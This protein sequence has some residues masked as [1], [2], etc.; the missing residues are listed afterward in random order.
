MSTASQDALVVVVGRGDDPSRWRRV[1]PAILAEATASV[2]RTAASRTLAVVLLPAVDAVRPGPV[3]VLSPAGAVSSYE[4]HLAA[5][6]AA[7]A[8]CR[9]EHVNGRGAAGSALHSGLPARAAARTA[10]TDWRE[11]ANPRP[12]RSLHRLSS[13][14]SLLVVSVPPGSADA[15][16]LVADHPDA[17]IVLVF[18]AVHA[19]HGAE[20]AR[21]VG[22]MVELALGVE[23]SGPE[24][25]TPDVPGAPSVEDRPS[26]DG[27]R[28]GGALTRA[29]ND[30]VT[31]SDPPRSAAPA[32][33]LPPVRASDVIHVRL[34][35]TALE[36]TNRTRQRVRCRIGLG[37]T[38]AT[39]GARAV[40]SAPLDPGEAHVEPTGSIAEIAGLATPEPVMRT[41]SH[42]RAEVYEGGERRIR[43]VEI[44]VLDETGSECATRTYPAPNGLDFSLTGRDLATLLGREPAVTVPTRPAPARA[45][46]VSAPDILAALRS[47]L[48][49]GAGVLARR[50]G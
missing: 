8:R 46:A 24:D 28:E 27:A 38:E 33:A 12:E 43:Y 29:G 44:T 22:S 6:F 34:T 35:D 36:L 17:D 16:A 40:F 11:I 20:V 49:T 5:A 14:P 3:A 7:H 23:L 39:E 32:E 37:S 2:A 10:V 19:R 50:S 21:Q 48:D 18:D 45:P 13:R 4:V 15:A 9:V 31:R 26:G 1:G 42:S 47:A 30:S 25:E 41:W